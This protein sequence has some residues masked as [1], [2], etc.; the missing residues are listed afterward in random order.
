MKTPIWDFLKEYAD[1]GYARA[2][3]PGHKG[4]GDM[5]L[6]KYDIT[7]IKGADSLFSADGIIAESEGVASELFGAKTF[8]STEGSSHSIRAMLYLCVKHAHE[9]G[10]RCKILAARGVHKVF[11][12]AAAALD[13]D[14]E[15]LM[16]REASYLCSG[17]T[18]EDVRAALSSAKELPTA[19]YVTSPNY[20]GFCLDIKRIAEACHDFGVLLLVDNAHGA[21]LVA[22]GEHPIELGA[23]AASDSAHKTLSAL[24]GGAY[25]HIS[26]NAPSTFESEA[27]SA[28]SLFGST[29][30]SYLILA[31]L[32]LANP[33]L[34]S[35]KNKLDVTI[36][37]IHA[38][39]D[40]LASAGY[41]V[42]EGEPLKITVE[43]AKYGYTGEELSEL[44]IA[45]GVYPEF[46]DRD[47]LVLMLSASSDECDIRAIENALTK[48]PPRAPILDTTPVISLPDAKMRVRDAVLSPSE[49]L[50]V[51]EC[52]GRILSAVTVG[53]PPAVPILVSGEVVDKLS[54][55][56]FKYY[57][58]KTL[59]VVKEDKT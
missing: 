55:D 10:K 9:S 30:P 33:Y 24:T 38:L 50:P 18:P 21:Y 31:S 19:L 5:G 2:H 13:F 45:Q 28:L 49:I 25:L 3:M 37:K 52:E 41:T 8:F 32:D 4:R 36:P 22:L 51:S 11:V 6:E 27:R 39:K 1:G 58:I 15:W 44:L 54:L 34:E 56:A 26:K 57:G 46:A 29:S 40:R 47:Y 12:S 59:S 23:D 16:P 43:A 7:E 53:C 48:I 35:L 14:I 42:L 17:L 20:L